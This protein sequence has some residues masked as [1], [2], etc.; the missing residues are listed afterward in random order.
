ML[1][2]DLFGPLSE[3]LLIKDKTAFF[4]S[5]K[6]FLNYLI[7]KGFSESDFLENK[8]EEEVDNMLKE[9]I[10]EIKKKN[11][12]FDIQIFF[13]YLAL[14]K[15]LFTKKEIDNINEIGFKY[16]TWGIIKKKKYEEHIKICQ[17][18]LSPKIYRCFEDMAFIDYTFGFPDT[19]EYKMSEY[20]IMARD[21]FIL[22]KGKDPYE[23][24]RSKSLFNDIK[25]EMEEIYPYLKNKYQAEN[26][27]QKI[28]NFI[29][30]TPYDIDKTD[31]K[32][33]EIYKKYYDNKRKDERECLN[34]KN[35]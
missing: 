6:Y 24:Y 34:K 14:N 31:E 17:K 1:A 16:E 11:E 27:F 28:Y 8:N 3:E 4:E 35:N 22:D 32:M 12:E 10:S 21:Y 26:F 19:T 18:R 20:V 23:N 30:V 33:K 9:K 13:N 29:F 15:N 25:K 2:F 5:K 7:S